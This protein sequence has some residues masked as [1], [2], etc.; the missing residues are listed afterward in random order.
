M[1]TEDE[2]EK[3]VDR[4]AHALRIRWLADEI[5]KTATRAREAVEFRVVNRTG[6]ENALP[7]YAA[8]LE[9]APVPGPIDARADEWIVFQTMVGDI[10]LTA[11]EFDVLLGEPQVGES[12]CDTDELDLMLMAGRS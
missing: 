10:L 6:R 1:I 12:L 2:I 7:K 8:T 5:D 9:L 11:G 4:V 3:N